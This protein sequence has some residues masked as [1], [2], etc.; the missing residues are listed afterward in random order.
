MRVPLSKVTYTLE[1]RY[2][3]RM[4]RW[5]LNILDPIG[6]PILM[7][8]PLLNMRDVTGQYKHLPVPKGPIFSIDDSGK[9]L[10]PTLSSFLTDH[11]LIYIDP[12]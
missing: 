4:G 5:I 9:G 8:L 10:E 7:G 3:N 2:N 12:T 11:G 1:L 6:A